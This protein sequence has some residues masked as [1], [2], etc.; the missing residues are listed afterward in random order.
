MPNRFDV[1]LARVRNEVQA[2]I[3]IGSGSRQIENTS[4]Q[5]VA[6]DF[7]FIAGKGPV[8]KAF[9]GLFF[10]AEAKRVLAQVAIASTHGATGFSNVNNDIAS[11][12]ASQSPS[13]SLLPTSVQF[14]PST[15][16]TASGTRK[17]GDVTFNLPDV[18]ET[19]E[20]WGL[21][22]IQQDQFESLAGG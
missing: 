17:N 18:D 10:N 11:E 22:G 6:V 3:H 9:H 8:A 4:G 5:N 19:T 14:S 2:E 7:T 20:I 16:G 15:P 12:E 21:L 1:F 13:K